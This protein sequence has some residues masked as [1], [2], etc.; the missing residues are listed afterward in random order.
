MATG[1]FPPSNTDPPR[2]PG[3]A[4]I[5]RQT[6]VDVGSVITRNVP[7][8]SPGVAAAAARCQHA[9]WPSRRWR[10]GAGAARV[11]GLAPRRP[12]SAHCA[13]QLTPGRGPARPHPDSSK[14]ARALELPGA[15]TPP[16]AR[17]HLWRIVFWTMGFFLD[18]IS[19]AFLDEVELKGSNIISIPSILMCTIHSTTVPS[20]RPPQTQAASSRRNNLTSSC[21]RT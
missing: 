6:A 17:H 5:H 18:E 1:A 9:H 10:L 3:A 20:P 13:L 8:G 12:R 19:F 11:P 4:R 14:L 21:C 7:G 2:A 16:L 15:P